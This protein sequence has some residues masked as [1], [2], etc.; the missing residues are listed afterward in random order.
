M[1]PKVGIYIDCGKIPVRFFIKMRRLMYYWHILH[2]D[3]DE[4]IYKFYLAQRYSPSEGDWVHQIRKDMTELKL[5]LSEEDIK[6]MSQYKL[7]SLIRNRIENLQFH[8]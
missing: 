4:L 7:K 6:S 3:E 2:R 8:I 5:E 1:S